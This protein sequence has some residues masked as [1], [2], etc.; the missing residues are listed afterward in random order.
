MSEGFIAEI[1]ASHSSL[2]P[3]CGFFNTTNQSFLL[4]SKAFYCPKIL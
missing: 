3:T 2:L 1:G 4:T